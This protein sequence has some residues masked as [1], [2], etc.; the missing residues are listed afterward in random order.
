MQLSGRICQNEREINCSGESVF[1]GVIGGSGLCNLPELE[2]TEEIDL[3]TPY[4]EPSDTVIVGTYAGVRIAFVP[5]H[6]SQHGIPP[7]RVPYKA[8]LFALKS[9]GV[10]SV[11]ATCVAGSLKREIEPGTF[12]VP[13]Q[14]INLTWGR[15][16]SYEQDRGFIHLPMAQPYCQTLARALGGA[17][18]EL[19]LPHRKN[20]TVVVIQGPRFSTIAESRMYALWGGDIVNMTQYPE[21]YF[22]R[23]LGI[24]YSVLSSITDYDVGVSSD[25]AMK[26][27]S[28]DRVIPVFKSNIELTK[29]V[30]AQV[31]QHCA[32]FLHCGCADAEIRPYYSSVAH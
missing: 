3:T 24:C 30:L 12:V 15:D 23:E 21:C 17:L 11:F 16:D 14:F 20:G 8:N 18:Q 29:R 2:V 26:R 7:H 19:A 27:G 25:I 6:G 1:I 28:F 4:G 32:Q 10:R 22:A 5:R 13:D 31:L 9:L